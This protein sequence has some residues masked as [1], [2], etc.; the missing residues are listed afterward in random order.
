MTELQEVL[1]TI[2][3][4]DNTLTQTR[5]CLVNAKEVPVEGEMRLPDPQSIRDFYADYIMF[6]TAKMTVERDSLT[7]QT[8]SQSIQISMLGILE[9]LSDKLKVPIVCVPEQKL[10]SKPPFI[11]DMDD[12]IKHKMDWI[13]AEFNRILAL[14]DPRINRLCQDYYRVQSYPIIVRLNYL[15]WE[16]GFISYHIKQT[17]TRLEE[18]KTLEL[19]EIRKQY[20]ERLDKEKSSLNLRIFQTNNEIQ[21]LR[22]V[23]NRLD[24]LYQDAQTENTTLKQEIESLHNKSKGNE[25]SVTKYSEENSAL[26]AEVEILKNRL[27]KYES[28]EWRPD[29]ASTNSNPVFCNQKDNSIVKFPCSLD[30]FKKKYSLHRTDGKTRIYRCLDGKEFEIPESLALKMPVL[31]QSEQSVQHVPSAQLIHATQTER[32]TAKKNTIRVNGKDLA[33][34]EGTK[35]VYDELLENELPMSAKEIVGVTQKPQP[36]V[37]GRFLKSLREIGVLVE[38]EIDGV[39][40]YSINN[41]EDN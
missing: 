25:E 32:N 39:K 19:R 10:T 7:L 12:V 23:N 1:K 24:G 14:G 11:T 34:S 21:R 4:L 3:K 35:I 22:T 29:F 17:E 18:K 20:S 41:P 5:A 8:H 30:E 6:K 26:K 16:R 38:K 15:D 40:K 37:S 2:D 13:F 9:L 28:A 31:T 27:N 33:V 36:H